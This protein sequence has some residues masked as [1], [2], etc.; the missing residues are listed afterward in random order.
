MTLGDQAFT[1]KW[2]TQ[3]ALP[4]GRRIVVVTDKPIAFVGGAAVGAKSRA[5]YEVAVI[6]F[7]IDK[8][9]QGQG[10]MAAAARVRPGGDTG[11]LIDDYAEAL[12]KLTKVTKGN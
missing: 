9:G 2:A 8:E 10:E 4:G 5:G 1:I 7:E 6:R 3:E 11:V 12:I